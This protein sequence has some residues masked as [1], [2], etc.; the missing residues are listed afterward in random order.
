MKRAKALIN[1]GAKPT[2]QYGIE[3]Y[4]VADGTLKALR[5]GIADATGRPPDGPAARRQAT[6]LTGPG[7]AQ[8]DAGLALLRLAEDVDVA[9]RG[10]ERRPGHVEEAAL[11]LLPLP[12][13]FGRSQ[14]RRRRE[15]RRDARLELPVPR[16]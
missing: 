1:T 8:L 3:A 9:G 2:W 15:R 6:D 13:V 14:N 5:T 11:A 10:D 7:I 12:V 16:P 4:G